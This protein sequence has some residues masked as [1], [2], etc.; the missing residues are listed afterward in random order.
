MCC[1]D[2]LEQSSVSDFKELLLIS[3][4]YLHTFNELRQKSV[5]CMHDGSAQAAV[6]HS[7]TYL[8]TIS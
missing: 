6:N 4:L 1:S 3:S 2:I 8:N 7:S 5:L